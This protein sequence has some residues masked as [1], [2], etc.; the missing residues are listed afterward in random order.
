MSGAWSQASINRDMA[1]FK[2]WYVRDIPAASSGTVK[3]Y[4]IYRATTKYS[5][6]FKGTKA[7]K[8]MY[9]DHNGHMAQWL[10]MMEGQQSLTLHWRS[11]SRWGSEN[12]A[13]R[14]GYKGGQWFIYD[15]LQHIGSVITPNTW[16]II[17]D[18]PLTLIFRM[19]QGGYHNLFCL[20]RQPMIPLWLPAHYL[21]CDNPERMTNNHCRS[22]VAHFH[23]GARRVS[24]SVLPKMAANDS[25]VTACNI[26]AVWLPRT[27]DQ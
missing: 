21:R 19:G 16:P 17:I 24:Q 3:T 1:A 13:I 7:G 27:H 6:A 14:F 11:F 12:S 23:D 5:W 15:C 4:F 18:T 22:V 25:F 26:S 2:S 20:Y 8:T 10:T 9:I